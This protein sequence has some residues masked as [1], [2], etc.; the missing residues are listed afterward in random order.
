MVCRVCEES[1]RSEE[2]HLCTAFKEDSM[3]CSQNRDYEVRMKGMPRNN[4]LMNMSKSYF[5]FRTMN[6]ESRVTWS[7]ITQ[8]AQVLYQ[9]IF[10]DL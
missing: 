8:I 1:S 10:I 5:F 4:F 9:M 7:R 2:G 6:K 3:Y